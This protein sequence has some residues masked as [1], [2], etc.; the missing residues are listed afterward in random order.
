MKKLIVSGVLLGLLFAFSYAMTSVFVASVLSGFKGVGS[1]DYTKSELLV[2][3][4]P[5][6]GLQSSEENAVSV[7]KTGKVQVTAKVQS[8]FKVQE[9]NNGLNGLVGEVVVE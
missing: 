2:N 6:G 3:D 4:K 7:Q 8:T 9:T 5:Y 1:E